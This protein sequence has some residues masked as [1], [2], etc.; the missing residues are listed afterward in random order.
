MI[1]GTHLYAVLPFYCVC[2]PVSTHDGGVDTVA[3]AFVSL[4]RVE[5]IRSLCMCMTL[6]EAERK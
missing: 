3:G 5:C 4:I 2:E 1:H 6:H